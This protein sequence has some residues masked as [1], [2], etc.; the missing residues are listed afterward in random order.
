MRS[1][2]RLVEQLVTATALGLSAASVYFTPGGRLAFWQRV[3]LDR[4]GCRTLSPVSS[5]MDDSL[6][7]GKPSR[8]VTMQPPRPQLSLAI[9]PWV[10]A[11]STRWLLPLLRKKTASSA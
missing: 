11:M 8:Y 3:A 9:P 2:E 7:A 10:A 5:G 4:R 1:L 6:R